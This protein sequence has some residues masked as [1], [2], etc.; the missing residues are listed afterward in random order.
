M[1]VFTRTALTVETPDPSQGGGASPIS[2]AAAGG[3]DDGVS[4]S[5]S[6]GGPTDTE[7]KTGRW[8]DFGAQLANVVKIELKYDFDWSWNAIADLEDEGSCSSILSFFFADLGDSGGA[9]PLNGPGGGH[10]ENSDSDIGSATI[11]LP[12]NTD[13]ANFQ[14]QCEMFAEAESGSSGSSGSASADVSMTITNLRV[15]ITTA[16]PAVIFGMM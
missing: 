2:G 4:V 12:N 11:T 9:G 6:G 13:L 1:A 3:F 10:D 14:V 15:V 7:R 8:R 5:S 16:E